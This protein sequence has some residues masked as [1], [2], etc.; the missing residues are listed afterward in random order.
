[1]EARGEAFHG[2]APIH[3]ATGRLGAGECSAIALAV[4]RRY[5]LAM[6]DRLATTRARRADAT[7]RILATQDL[8]VSMINQGLRN[9]AEADRIKQEW[10]TR[11]RFRLRLGSFRD[12]L[13]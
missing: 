12:L 6:D 7:L 11:H 9:I 5:V 10:A 13:E 2:V 4:H 3:F 1:M 8:V